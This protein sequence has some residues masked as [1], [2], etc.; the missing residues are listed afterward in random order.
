VTIIP[1]GIQGT[2]ISN[3]E[4]DTVTKRSIR[5]IKNDDNLCAARAIVTA[6]TYLDQEYTVRLGLK[7]SITTSA[8]DAIIK[9]DDSKCAIQRDLARKLLDVC[10][11]QVPPADSGLTLEDIRN[12]EKRI[13]VQINIVCVENFNELIDNENSRNY[14]DKIYLF[15]NHNHFDVITSITG[16]YGCVYNCDIHKTRLNNKNGCSKCNTVNICLICTGEIHEC[17]PKWIGCPK[18]FRYF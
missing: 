10:Q 15:K 18:C 17:E 11:I 3:I 4:R 8:A 5:Q 1:Q 16:F 9:G 6:L 13:E 14:S 2:R 7:D 12:I